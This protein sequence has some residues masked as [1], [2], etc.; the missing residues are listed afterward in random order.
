MTK[1]TYTSTTIPGVRLNS[2]TK[3][4]EVLVTKFAGSYD[5][6]KEAGAVREKVL[7][8]IASLFP[9]KPKKEKKAKAEKK[10]KSKPKA[11]KKVKAKATK[12]P[13]KKAPKSSVPKSEQYRDQVP[14]IAATGD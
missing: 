13:G 9:E 14:P 6:L 7:G 3:Q 10:S 11:A 8:K 2:R 12:E 1:T 5:T 4:Y